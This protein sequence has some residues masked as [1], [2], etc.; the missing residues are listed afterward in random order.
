MSILLDPVEVFSV[1]DLDSELGNQQLSNHYGFILYSLEKD[2]RAVGK[3]NEED[4]RM[5][6][7]LEKDMK[8]F[9]L[10]SGY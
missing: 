4:E 1:L 3:F 6:I 7:L 5:Y 8:W 10:A 2:N 9:E